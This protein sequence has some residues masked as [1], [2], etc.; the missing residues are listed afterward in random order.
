M[1]RLI[2]PG[3]AIGAALAISACGG[4][5]GGASS[6]TGAPAR[7]GGTVSVQ[8]LSGV[9]RVLVD[10]SGKALYT[11]NLEANGKIVCTGGCNAFWK[12]VTAAGKPT[13]TGKLGVVKRPDGTMQVTAGGRP[14]YTFTEDSP[15]KATGDG[16][17]D[18]FSG[19]QFTWHAVRSGGKTSSG[20]S[21]AAAPSG[22]GSGNSYG[23]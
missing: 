14:L 7:G 5:G 10:R 17:K 15:G 22:G 1:K 3:F 23:Y 21:A 13:G 9:G 2:I 11:P 19:H 16:F 4:G 12:P 8:Q 20:G 6:T 18:A